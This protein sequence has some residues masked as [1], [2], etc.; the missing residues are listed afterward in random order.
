MYKKEYLLNGF[1][2]YLLQ[3][4]RCT[5]ISFWQVILMLTSDLDSDEEKDKG[6]LDALLTAI[7]KEL[8]LTGKVCL[9]VK[10]QNT[11]QITTWERK[12]SMHWY[13]HLK[14][15]THVSCCR[16]HMYLVVGWYFI[17]LL[18][19]ILS[20]LPAGT[21]VMRSSSF[22]WDCSVFCYQEPRQEINPQGR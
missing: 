3:Y 6:A 19:R 5:C 7:I 10:F 13:L 14:P 12:Y 9:F 20:R 2:V 11:R 15:I 16:I 21:S 4:M 17:L 18:I 8:D 1:W 22:C